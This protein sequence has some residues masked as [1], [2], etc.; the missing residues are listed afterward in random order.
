M[1]SA[2]VEGFDTRRRQTAACSRDDGVDAEVVPHLG[3][4]FAVGLQVLLP[5]D[6]AAAFA[7]LPEAFGAYAALAVF[8]LGQLFV[9]RLCRA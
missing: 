2:V 8:Q 6:L 9:G 1:V 5:D 7:L 3:Q 4:T